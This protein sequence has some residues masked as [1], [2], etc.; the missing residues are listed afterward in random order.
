MPTASES[1]DPGAW[2]EPEPPSSKLR[3]LLLCVSVL[4][5]AILLVSGVLAVRFLS[6]LHTEEL[7]VTRAL[8]ERTQAL[9]GLWLSIQ[10][11]NHA[12]QQLVAQTAGDHDVEPRRRLEQLTVE[13]DADFE[14]YP[15]VRDAKEDALL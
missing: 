3:W 6:D 10:S 5:L 7:A 8:S 4:L 2:R 11:Y 15:S 14:R 1:A 12:V 13:I 9:S